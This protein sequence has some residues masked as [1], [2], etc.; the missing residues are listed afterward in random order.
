MGNSLGT[1]FPGVCV[2]ACFCGVLYV[3]VCVLSRP[4]CV[5]GVCSLRCVCVYVCMVCIPWCVC[6]FV[7]LHA[8]V[9]G[10]L[11]KYTCTCVCISTQEGGLLGCGH[12]F[13]CV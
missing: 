6:A 10:T 12:N 7:S 3:E 1:V 4:V 5:R 9:C 13:V 2:C 8:R 11:P